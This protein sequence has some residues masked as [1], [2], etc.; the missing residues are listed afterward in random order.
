MTCY[1]VFPA[2]GS[3]PTLQPNFE[4]PLAFQANDQRLDGRVSADSL[5]PRHH[6]LCDVI[7]AGD[8]AEDVDEDGLHLSEA[9]RSP[10]MIPFSNQ[11]Q[12]QCTS[13][14]RCFEGVTLGSPMMILACIR[15]A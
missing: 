15:N 6:G 11:R 9:T 2:A 7:A 5:H 10:G 14:A 12:A 8:A 4:K 1:L 13:N 3:A